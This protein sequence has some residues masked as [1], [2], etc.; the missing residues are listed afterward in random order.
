MYECTRHT[1]TLTHN[2]THTCQE[3]TRG[4]EKLQSSP[5]LLF[6]TCLRQPEPKHRPLQW[7][8]EQQHVDFSE[9]SH[10]MYNCCSDSFKDRKIHT[11]SHHILRKCPFSL[12]NMCSQCILLSA[13]IVNVALYLLAPSQ[14]ITHSDTS[15][16][17]VHKHTRAHTQNTSTLL[18]RSVIFLLCPVFCPMTG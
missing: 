2:L 16:M 14:M 4:G 6:I 8:S 9:L 5:S 17:C 10:K 1:Y 7:F 3:M 15:Y 12:T 13:G 11:N 18:L